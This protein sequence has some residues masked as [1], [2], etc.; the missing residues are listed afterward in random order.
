VIRTI[1]Q[2]VLDYLVAAALGRREYAWLHVSIDGELRRWGGCSS[3]L[4]NADPQPGDQLSQLVESLEGA[5]PS[6]DPTI[7]SPTLVLPSVHVG[8]DRVADIHLFPDQN[9]YYVLLMDCTEITL[10]EQKEQQRRYEVNLHTDRRKRGQTQ[11]VGMPGVELEKAG[12]VRLSLLCARLQVSEGQAGSG[13]P[14]STLHALDR[15]IEVMLRPVL[16]Q[17]GVIDIIM[18]GILL[19][20]FGLPGT[21]DSPAMDSVTAG[22]NVIRAVD[23]FRVDSAND[24]TRIKVGLGIVS[25]EMTVG[26]IGINGGDRLGIVGHELGLA[27]HYGWLATPGEMLIDG[28]T[29]GL[30]E[31]AREL[32]IRADEDGAPTNLYSSKV[33]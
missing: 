14:E 25:G 13:T 16:E 30:L 23:E 8:N 22:E 19:A 17:H 33:M 10:N 27:M 12:N 20:V 3:L 7:L 32:F 24:V 29:F 9:S 31:S 26:S 18:G 5:L 28:H 6:D 1:P 11:Y 15:Y 21:G 2:P 4:A